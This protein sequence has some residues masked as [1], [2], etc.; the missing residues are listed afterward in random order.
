M[1][2]E[3]M[4]GASLNNKHEEHTLKKLTVM[5]CA[6]MKDYPHKVLRSKYYPLDILE[7]VYEIMYSTMCGESYV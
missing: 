1:P 6:M 5:L 4:T 2:T 7:C 3:P